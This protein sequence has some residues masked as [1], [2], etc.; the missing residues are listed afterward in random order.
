[1][2]GWKA[3]SVSHGKT[4]NEDS[5]STVCQQVKDRGKKEG[6]NGI[7]KK[8]HTRLWALSPALQ[9]KSHRVVPIQSSEIPQTVLE[10][11]T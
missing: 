10:F 7:K 2:Q 6:S 8:R 4:Y 5:D 3:M 1:M 9:E 11:P